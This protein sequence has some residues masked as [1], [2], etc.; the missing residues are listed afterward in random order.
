M[1]LIHVAPTDSVGS[2]S[3]L[4]SWHMFIC[5]EK[6]SPSFSFQP[7][8]GLSCTSSCEYQSNKALGWTVTVTV[9]ID[10]NSDRDSDCCKNCTNRT[11]RK[12]K[13]L[14]PKVFILRSVRF[15]EFL[16]WSVER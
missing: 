16:Q 3:V 7:A 8:H 14:F 11:D 5:A 2:G 12:M 10:R 4:L 13:T 6:Q 9:P 15:V 1:N